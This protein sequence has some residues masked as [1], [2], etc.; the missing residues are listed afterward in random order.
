MKIFR[1]GHPNAP[2]AVGQFAGASGNTGA[3]V[4][5]RPIR[6]A[7]GEYVELVLRTASVTWAYGYATT[8]DYSI[9]FTAEL[10]DDGI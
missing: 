6:F 8:P 10:Y 2:V 1:N 7:A 3:F 4:V 9:T 5:S